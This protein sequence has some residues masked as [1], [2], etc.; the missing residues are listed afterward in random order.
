M[1]PATDRNGYRRTAELMKALSHPSRLRILELLEAEDEACVCHLEQR[2]GQRQAYISQQLAKLRQAGLVLDRR[3]G[4]NVFYALSDKGVA[5][6][7]ANARGLAEILARAEGV[8]L[9]FS[10]LRSAPA[11][12]CNCPK[13]SAAH[14]VVLAAE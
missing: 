8:Q 12:D 4:L 5:A 13:C 3:D 11:A 14:E 2:L 1:T 6:L 10:L 7:A 9:G